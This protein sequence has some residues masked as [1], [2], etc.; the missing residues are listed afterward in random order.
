MVE[1]VFFSTIL[2]QVIKLRLLGFSVASNFS[3]STISLGPNFYL[4]VSLAEEQVTLGEGDVV[5]N[6][7]WFIISSLITSNDNFYL[8]TQQ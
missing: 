8:P 5:P 6:S 1:W 3:G 7:A 2:C 4:I